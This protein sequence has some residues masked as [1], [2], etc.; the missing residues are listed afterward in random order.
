MMFYKAATTGIYR[1]LH[2]M[3]IHDPESFVMYL[4]N[5][6]H[7]IFFQLFER[8]NSCFHLLAPINVE[9][10]IKCLNCCCAACC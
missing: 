9:Q 5:W 2:C 10:E 4:S 1:L 6:C 7:I 3:L 8:K